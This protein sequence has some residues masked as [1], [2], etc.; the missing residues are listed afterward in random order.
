[1][2]GYLLPWHERQDG[3][4]LEAYSNLT[5]DS[6]ETRL[7]MGLITFG[8]FIITF[9]A[10]VFTC[11]M[12]WKND[13]RMLAPRAATIS[14]SVALAGP[15]VYVQ[16]LL[17][18]DPRVDHSWSDLYLR[19]ADM[20]PGWFLAILFGA[21]TVIVGL[22]MLG[23]KHPKGSVSPCAHELGGVQSS[24]FIAVLA[25]GSVTTIT[26]YFQVWS[27]G[28]F[29]TA[30]GVTELSKSGTDEAPLMCL[31]PIAA[32]AALSLAVLSHVFAYRAGNALLH[33]SRCA[34]AMGLSLTLLWGLVI[35]DF[36]MNSRSIW[37]EAS[38]QPGW[39]VFL[40]GQVATMAGL[41][42]IQHGG[43]REKDA[44]RT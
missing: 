10:M 9:A 40:A 29:N 32:G 37:G 22:C 11:W 7:E 14:A 34:S 4:L 33:A 39:Y 25:I 16:S 8:C 12:V 21:A 31:V 15:L 23:R 28:D 42:I 18:F 13:S 38:L 43:W 1:M 24:V 2:V 17:Q 6:T 36:E 20:G 26:G 19:L 27:S 3:A 30:Y 35:G 44:P 41:T 5:H